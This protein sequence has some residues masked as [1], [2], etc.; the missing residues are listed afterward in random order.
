[1]EQ[2]LIFQ[3]ELKK[4]ESKGIISYAPPTIDILDPERL[5]MVLNQ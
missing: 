2:Q 5:Q 1:M 3:S 4:L